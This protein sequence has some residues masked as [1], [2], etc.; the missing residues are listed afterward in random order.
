MIQLVR[1]I[2]HFMKSPQA[3]L[4]AKLRFER[5]YETSVNLL[6]RIL[7]VVV[8]VASILVIVS[9]LIYVGFE[10]D[11]IDRKLILKLLYVGQLI[12]VASVL[13]NWIFRFETTLHESLWL[14]RIIDI[15]L[16][17]TLIPVLFPHTAQ[18]QGTFAHLLHN[19]YLFFGGVG[20]YALAEVS[21]GCMQLL[22]RRTNPSLILSVSF[23]IFILLGSFVLMLPRCTHGTI[24]YID[25][26]FMAAS[27]V[28]MTGMSTI[29]T[30]ATFTPLG[31]TVITVLVQIGALGV[32]TFT[33]FFAMFFSGRSS[34]Y[35]QLL[36]RDF[37]YSK[38][39]S[40]LLPVILYILLFTLSVEAIGAACIFAALPADF[41]GTTLEKL[42]FSGFHSISAFCNAG[43]STLPDGMATPM[44]MNGNQMLYVVLTVLIV[45]GGIGFPNLVNFKDALGNYFRRLKGLITGRK[46]QRVVHVYD[47]NTKL[48]LA[49]T[50]IL[51]FG[52]ALA[53]FLLEHNGVLAGMPLSKKITQS[54]FGSAAVRTAGFSSFP[55]FGLGNGMFLIVMLLMWIG[56]SSQSMG[57]GIKVNTF[58]AVVLNLRSIIRGQKGVAVYHRTIASSSIRRANAVVLLFIFAYIVYTFLIMELE[59][60]LKATDIAFE[61]FSAL[62]TVGFTTGITSHLGVLSKLLLA[63]AMFAGRVGV[64]SILC[65]IFRNLPDRAHMYPTDDIIIS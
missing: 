31:W 38:S 5:R 6:A 37:I 46:A 29:D 21:L 24:S 26:L 4:G 57:G 11:H 53:F 41:P 9:L 59:P 18:C 27:A 63:S 19:R 64:L 42:A 22:G 12:F 65:G 32:L 30:A 10:H 33:S 50:A 60:D 47:L 45:A 23:L 40:S 36:M 49:T 35:N 3:K 25:A 15:L 8:F 44:L 54:F 34:I 58:A 62:T 14:K 48:V 16:L 52:G 61:T 7:G 1:H 2:R 39:M 56:C 20:I 17:L 55:I 51:F 43:F 13:F 28:S